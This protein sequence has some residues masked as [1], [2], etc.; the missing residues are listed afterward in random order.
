M[1][2]APAPAP[3]AHDSAYLYNEL[4]KISQELNNMETT[5][6]GLEVARGN[7]PGMSKVNKFGRCTD[8][9][10]GVDTDIADMTSG[11]SAT[12]VAPTAARV[13]AIVSTSTSDTNTAGAGARTVQVYGLTSWTAVE[14]SEVIELDGTTPVNTTNSYVIIHRM[15][16]LTKGATNVNVGVITATAATDSTVTAQI[17]AGEGQTQMAV[18]GIPS[19]V[20]A[21][22]TRYYASAIKG[23]LSISVSISLL[24]NP[25][26]DSELTNFLVKHTQGL[27]TDGSN[28][29]RHEFDPPRPGMDA[30]R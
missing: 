25:E 7:V 22:M 16:V 2:Y 24:A 20:T 1:S 3:I 5:D 8:V 12:W 23:A 27:A 28:Y 17:N 10:S 14:T 11:T 18:Y 15:K 19:G 4:L 26:P 30:V 9:D 6:Y 13:H 29:I 21:Y